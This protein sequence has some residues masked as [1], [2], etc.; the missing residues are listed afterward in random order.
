MA[1]RLRIL[2]TTLGTRG[3]VQPYVALAQGLLGRGHRVLLAAPEQFASFAESHGIDVEPLPGAFLALLDTDEGRAAIAGGRGFGAGLKLLGHV[4][5][6]MR[7]LFDAEWSAARRLHPDVLVHHP[8]SLAAPHIAERVGIPAV[9]ASPLPGFTPTRA[10][11]SPLLPFRTLGPLNRASHGPAIRSG[12]ILFGR[13]LAAWRAEVLGLG[14]RRQRPIRRP[15]LYAYSPQVLP[16]PVDWGPEVLVTGY[17]I[18]EDDSGWVPS[19]ALAEFLSRGE[20][21]VYVG[22]GSMPGIDAEGLARVVTEALA[23]AGKRG[24]LAVGQGAL[25]IRDAPP[26]VQVIDGA[27]HDRLF[28]RMAA[29]L[30][31]GGAGTTGASLRAGLPTLVCPFFGDQPFWGRRVADLGAGPPPLD[32]RRLDA[33]TLAAAFRAADDLGMRRRAAELGHSIGAEDGV[34][35]AVAFLERQGARA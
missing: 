17:W 25:A 2:I 20:P 11:P 8:K 33:P 6:L 31:H 24:V 10:F 14:K 15:T 13:T 30:H 35:A 1:G 29:A 7:R 22:F 32:R 16:A 18:L 28:P 34:A 5:P 26:H 4:R 19:A 27:P 3:D 21:P 12:E 23:L 9:L